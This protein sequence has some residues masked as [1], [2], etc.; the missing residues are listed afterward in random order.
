MFKRTFSAVAAA[1]LTAGTLA[2]STPVLAA[3]IGE[4]VTIN[5]SDLNLETAAG[6]A[7]F[8]RRVKQAARSVCGATQRL[9]L[10]MQSAAK[11]CVDEVMAE[12]AAQVETASRGDAPSQLALGT[13]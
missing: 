8:E 6:R 11:A 5:Y 10:S 9:P 4:T 3:S 7:H 2:L 1:A 13:R 12:A